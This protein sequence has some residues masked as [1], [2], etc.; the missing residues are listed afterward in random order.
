[1]DKIYSRNRRIYLPKFNISNIPKGGKFQHNTNGFKN[2]YIRKKAIITVI[3][4]VAIITAKL[5]IQAITPIIDKQCINI[6]KGIATKVSNEQ[7]SKVMGKYKYEDMCIISKD[8]NRC[9]CND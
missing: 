2:K 6:A 8:S 1:M 5:I 9:Y 3:F 7:A 4:I